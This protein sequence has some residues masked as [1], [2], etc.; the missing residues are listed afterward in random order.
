M[1]DRAKVMNELFLYLCHNTLGSGLNIYGD[2]KPAITVP[3]DGLAPGGARPSAGTV[4][5][6]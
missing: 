6:V 3:A 1:Q 5:Y 4:L 2:L